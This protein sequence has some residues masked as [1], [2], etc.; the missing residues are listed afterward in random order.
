ML[1][2]YN[3]DASIHSAQDDVHPIFG[4]YLMSPGADYPQPLHSAVG[5]IYNRPLTQSQRSVCYNQQ[6]YHDIAVEE[7]EII[8]LKVTTETR[9]LSNVVIDPAHSKAIVSIVDNDSKF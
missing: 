9:T 7:D 1:H 3:V 2:Q 6:T 4:T 8:A 5:Q